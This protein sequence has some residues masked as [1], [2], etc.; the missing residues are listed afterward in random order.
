MSTL[1]PP[2]ISD[3]HRASAAELSCRHERLIMD[4]RYIL[5]DLDGTLTDSYEGIVNALRYALDKL[6][7]RPDPA[8]YRDVVGPPLVETFRKYYGLDDA[9]CDRATACFHEYYET[10]GKFENH[11]Y[12]GV[13]EM[14]QTLNAHG[15]KLMIA[16]A[17][18]EPLAVEIADHFEIS[19]YLCFIAGV[20]HDTLTGSR[21]SDARSS[22]LDVISYLLHTNDIKDPEH[23][24]MIGDRGGDMRAASSLGI[25]TLGVLYG[26]GTEEELRTAGAQA[27]VKTPK[28][29]TDYLLND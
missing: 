13:M 9:T 18:P 3:A 15:K 14:L 29:I 11:L 25:Q 26:Y 1:Q 4:K 6:S 2:R 24:V 8:S 10:R 23:A 16:T 17:K 28:E 27:M 19:P 5:F 20:N 22:K 7:I 12:D 21:P